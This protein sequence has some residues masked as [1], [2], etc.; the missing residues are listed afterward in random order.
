MVMTA[1]SR[2][3]IWEANDRTTEGGAGGVV[4]GLQ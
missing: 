1:P 2:V 3:V 4:K